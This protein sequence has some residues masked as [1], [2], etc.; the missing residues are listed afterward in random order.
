MMRK[1]NIGIIGFGTIGSGVLK[2]LQDNSDVIRKRLGAIVEVVKIADLDI[3][4]DRGVR[5]DSKLLTTEVQDVIK[6]PEVDV[7]V[8]LIEVMNQQDL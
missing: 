6:H 1:I 3:T 7:I 8:E 5:V 4:S 2:I